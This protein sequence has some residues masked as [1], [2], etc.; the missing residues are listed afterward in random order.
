MEWET[1]RTV[2]YPWQCDSMGHFATQHYMKVFDDATYHLLGHLGFA[3]SDV[4]RTRRGWADVSHSIE[5]CREVLAGDLLLV[6]SSVERIGRTSITYKSRLTRAAEKDKNCAVL[7]GVA[8][9]F[10]LERRVALELPADIRAAARRALHV[11]EL[12]QPAQ[13]APTESA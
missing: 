2:A 10:D 8:V 9:H 13:D 12:E 3:L 11:E 5:Y 1:A 6:L 7:T 4:T